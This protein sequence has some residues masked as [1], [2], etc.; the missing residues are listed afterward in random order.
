MA[1]I[2]RGE[3]RWADLNP[4]RGNE[5]EGKRPVL[6]LSHDVFNERSGTVISAALTGQPQRA[7][8]PLT[9]ALQSRDLPRKSWIKIS[10]IRTLAVER[11]GS[12][13]GRATPEEIAKAYM[14]AYELGCLGITVF[15]DC[16][17]DTQV[18][19]LGTGVKPALREIEEATEQEAQQALPIAAEVGF[20]A[21]LKVKPRP[22]TMKGVTYRSETPLGTAFITV[23]QNGEGE[24]FE[25][26][27]SV[28]KAGSD[29]SAVSEAI[30]RLIS[31]I[32][33]LPSPMSPR[34]RVEQ[35]VNQL[36]GIGGRRPMG[37]GKDRV[38]SLP[39][40]IAQVLAEYIGLTE[41]GVQEMQAA[42]GKAAVKA[43][44]MCPDCGLATLV[45]EEGCQKCYS[46]GFSE[47]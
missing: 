37:F 7:G 28:G 42:R 12:R 47:C 27:A 22:R 44:D 2:L 24:P 8:F 30:G 40:A 31:M 9:L 20:E 32:L 10:Q 17:K 29:T 33:R 5:Q 21:A 45:Y 38:R 34:E 6:I 36:S 23:N 1:R 19:H 15:R 43:G 39:D 26:F 18:L 14:M 16:C 11:I 35:I 41:P 13:L 25:V 3:I 46:C 4:V